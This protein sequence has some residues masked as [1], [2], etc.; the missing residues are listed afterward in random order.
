MKSRPI[1]LVNKTQ[2]IKI[3]HKTPRIIIKQV[4]RAGRDGDRG[5]QGEPGHGLPSGGVDGQ[6]LVKD[7]DV[8]FAYRWANPQVIDKNYVFDFTASSTVPVNH[9][10]NKYPS[11]TVIDSAGDEVTGEVHYVNTSQLI[12]RFNAPFSGRVTCN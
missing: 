4:G 10:L 9:N 1:K 7:T 6:Y 12:V 5:P 2:T 11:V 8:P 3:A